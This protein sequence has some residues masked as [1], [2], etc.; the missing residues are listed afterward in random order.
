VN[1]SQYRGCAAGSLGMNSDGTMALSLSARWLKGLASCGN[2]CGCD[3]VKTT[4]LPPPT[5]VDAA[6]CG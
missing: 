6:L 2:G 4:V 1:S 3:A 5:V